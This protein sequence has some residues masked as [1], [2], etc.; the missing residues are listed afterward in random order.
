MSA[1]MKKVLWSVLAIV[2]IGLIVQL[3]GVRR[4]W[5]AFKAGAIG[6]DW[7]VVQFDMNGKPF[8]A[9]KYEGV[10]VTNETNSDGIY[11]TDPAEHLVHISGWYDRVQVSDKKFSEAAR[12]LGVD[13]SKITNGRYIVDQ[14]PEVPRR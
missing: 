13:D 7:I 12:I 3:P 2:A 9:W 1:R 10:S 5:T 11:W 8:N 4:C 14:P 6:S